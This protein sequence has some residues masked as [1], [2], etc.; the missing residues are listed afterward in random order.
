MRI[1][2]IDQRTSIAIGSADEVDRFNDFVLPSVGDGP[3]PYA[4]G[5]PTTYGLNAGQTRT[6]GLDAGKSPQRSDPSALEH[7]DHQP[8]GQRRR[9]PLD[10]SDYG[11]DRFN[12]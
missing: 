2:G 5:Q 3:I 6:R 10:R 8:K 12:Y 1:Q 11:H 9:N 4:D 7:W